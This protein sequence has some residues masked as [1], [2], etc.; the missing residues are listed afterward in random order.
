MEQA[1]EAFWLLPQHAEHQD[2]HGE[3]RQ[4]ESPGRARVQ[5]IAVIV[6]LRQ[7]SPRWRCAAVCCSTIAPTVASKKVVKLEG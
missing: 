5:F 2:R 1:W 7:A 4:D 3:Q 6:R